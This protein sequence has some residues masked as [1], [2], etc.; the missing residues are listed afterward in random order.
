[1]SNGKIE[2]HGKQLTLRAIAQKE[3]LVQVTLAR[4]Y[5]NIGDIYLAV[6]LCKRNDIIMLKKDLWY[7]E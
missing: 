6:S 3:G 1:M 2:Y 5:K 7:N 4:Y